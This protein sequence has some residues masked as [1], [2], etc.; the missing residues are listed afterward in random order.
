MIIDR[1]IVIIFFVKVY[2]LAINVYLLG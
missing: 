1:V 2:L